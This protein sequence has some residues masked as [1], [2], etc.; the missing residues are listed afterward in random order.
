MALNVKKR[1]LQLMMAYWK[2]MT[3]E[4]WKRKE[5]KFYAP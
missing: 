4:I 5:M 2:Q 1:S 3:D